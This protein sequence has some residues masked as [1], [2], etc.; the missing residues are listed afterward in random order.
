MSDDS[1]RRRTTLI[2]LLLVLATLAVYWQ[3]GSHE[4]TNY[5]DPDYVT[6]NRLV[7]KGLTW[8]GFLWAFNNSFAW[9]P[10][11]WLS[12]MVDWQLF[13]LN[14]GAHHL[15]SVLFHIANSL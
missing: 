7:Q 4:F 3:V 14:P 1:N 13:G 9:H 6:E 11:T 12:H 5:D 8:E 10:L 2:C 15:M